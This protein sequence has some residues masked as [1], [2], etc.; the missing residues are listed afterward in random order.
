MIQI[1]DEN[2]SPTIRQ[3]AKEL[4]GPELAS[5]Y[6]N[7]DFHFPENFKVYR[8]A[9]VIANVPRAI[10]L[11]TIPA[12]S[13][14]CE[15]GG[16]RALSDEDFSLYSEELLLAAEEILIQNNC[17]I[18]C[19]LYD[20]ERGSAKSKLATLLGKHNWSSPTVNYIK[21]HFDCYSF[22]P[23][24]FTRDTPLDP[25]FEIFKWEEL[26]EEEKIRLLNL[27]SRFTYHPFISPF[28]DP[29]LIQ[30]INSLG[31]RTESKVVGWI[32]T[33]TPSFAPDTVCYS[34]FYIDPACRHQNVAIPLLK[35]SIA[36]QQ[37]SPLRWSYFVINCDYTE[38]NWMKF[39]NK[40]LAPYTFKIVEVIRRCKSFK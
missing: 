12:S 7:P 8:L 27:E 33:H 10:A 5:V 9:K 19:C 25:S 22:K 13:S 30:N 16:I 14:L 2:S 40:R 24:W 34:A 23:H 29:N 32:V 26:E 36:L 39:V 21:Y 6:F 28:A 20:H 35:K 3:L 31:L 17:L 38:E 18:A 4:A 15:L 37:Q 11:V 1:L